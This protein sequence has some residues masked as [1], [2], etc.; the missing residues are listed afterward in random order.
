M[1]ATKGNLLS[2]LLIFQSL[3]VTQKIAVAEGK[4]LLY[5]AERPSPAV[6]LLQVVSCLV[7]NNTK[8]ICK[9]PPK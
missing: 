4:G 6:G 9:P 2:L 5:I 3:S 1:A 8:Q 7:A